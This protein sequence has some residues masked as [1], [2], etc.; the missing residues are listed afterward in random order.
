MANIIPIHFEDTEIRAIERDGMPWLP[1]ADIARA[2]G[3]KRSDKVA[4]IYRRNR[5]E[6]TDQMAVTLKLRLSG[7]AAP[8]P[9]LLFSPRG[10]HLVGMFAR[11]DRARAFRRWVLDVLDREIGHTLTPAQKLALREA[12]AERVHAVRGEL[13]PAG[14]FSAIYRALYHAF[15]VSA[16]G[17]IPAARFDE[18]LAFVREW[19]PAGSE[20]PERPITPEQYR[21]L[22]AEVKKAVTGWC[23]GDGAGQHVWNLLRVAFNLRR[24]EEMPANL[25]GDALEMVREVGERNRQ[26]IAMMWELQRHYVNNVMCGNAPWTPAIARKLGRDA[27]RALPRPDWMQLRRRALGMAVVQ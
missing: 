21:A 5:D 25:Y 8:S 11:T 20:A 3:Y 17:E 19:T 13:P 2:L 16:Y 10:A 1:A 15:G 12:V 23:L 7:S 24:V 6:F 26:F 18:A 4:Q 14:F 9:V 22:A 27:M